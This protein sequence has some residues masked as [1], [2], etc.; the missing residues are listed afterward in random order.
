MPEEQQGERTEPASP[1]K[2]REAR[3]KGQVA[4]SQDLN[5]AVILLAA[6]LLLNFCR[7]SLLEGLGSLC[8]TLL[9]NLHNMPLDIDTIQAYTGVGALHL[10]KMLVPLFIGM[11][12]VGLGI[13]L[14]QVGTALSPKAL[15]PNFS[16]FDPIKGMKKLISLRGSV[17][18]VMSL[19]KITIVGAIL[20]WTLAD[21]I[22]EIIPTMQLSVGAIL[23]FLIDVCF[24]V[25]VRIAV[26]L[27]IIAILDYSY[28]RWQHEKDLKMSKQEVKEELKRYEGDPRIKQ[29]R[30]RTQRAI[31]QQRMMHKVPEAEVIIT[32]PTHLAIAL[33]YKRDTMPAPRVVAKGAGYVAQKIRELGI[34]HG[35]P[36]VEKKPLAQALFKT[37][38]VGMTIPPDL[39]QAVAEIL[40]Y[41]Y[42]LEKQ[43]SQTN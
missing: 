18:L 20:Y 32:N 21:K 8:R 19:V 7:E 41:V 38:E 3:E 14:L 28:Q 4:K 9:S 40:A 13:S 1:R 5:T 43:A 30:M 36:I 15:V 23:T 16:R 12:V 42:E 27:L 34:V 25:G 31:L 39:Y 26:A 11:I 6:L 17:K 29:R 35:I 22:N 33:E 37:V 24:T 2:R 10:L